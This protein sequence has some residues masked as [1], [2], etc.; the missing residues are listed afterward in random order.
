MV[1]KVSLSID[2]LLRVKLQKLIKNLINFSDHNAF[3]FSSHKFEDIQ[4]WDITD[5]TTIASWN[6]IRKCGI[7][8]YNHFTNS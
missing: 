6:Q 8:M 2:L 7:L 1:Y 3:I 4:K 5:Q